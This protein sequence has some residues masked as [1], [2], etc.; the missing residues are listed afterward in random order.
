M[1]IRQNSHGEG[2]L[3]TITCISNEDNVSGEDGFAVASVIVVGETECVLIDTQWTLSNAHRVV[4][5]ILETGKPLTKA[6]LTHA[7]PDH[8][9]GTEAFADAFPDAVFYMLPEDIEVVE[10]Q[11]FGKLEHWQTV[12]GKLNCPKKRLNLTPLFDDY[13]E[14]DGEKIEIH[15][16][17]WGDL[18]YNTVVYIPS[19]KTL[20]GS[21]VLFN[22][23]HPF[24]CEVSAKGRAKWR[25]DIDRLEKFG[26]E[27]IIPGHAKPGMEFDETTFK[28]MRDYIDATEEE[29]ANTGDVANFY[30]N[31]SLR[32]PKARLLR[33]NEMNSNVFKGGREWYYSDEEEEA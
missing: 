10:E 24:T 1:E 8:Y 26:A 18:K 28:F 14:I 23:A 16:K 21:D 27:V 2:K 3:R 19:I 4:A 13:I 11:L 31:M 15:K 6:F 29:M 7:H 32:F 5:E 22:Q 17:I 25:A 30:Y 12:I 33:S 20:Y 9:F